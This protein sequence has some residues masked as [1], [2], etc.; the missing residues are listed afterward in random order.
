MESFSC[1]PMLGKGSYG[2]VHLGI[3]PSGRLVAVKY[4]NVVSENE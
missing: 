3:L 1:G 2:T 4:V